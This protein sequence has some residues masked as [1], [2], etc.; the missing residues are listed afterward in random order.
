MPKKTTPTKY[1]SP[2]QKIWKKKDKRP[3]GILNLAKQ[4]FRWMEIQNYS[5][6]TIKGY[7][8]QL[9][10]FLS[11]CHESS[12]YQIH[13]I[14][15]KI[16][17]KYKIHLSQRTSKRKDSLISTSAQNDFLSVVC[18]FFRWLVK[19]E[20]VLNNSCEEVSY[21]PSTKK[22][23]RDTLNAEEVEHVL[24]QTDLT[25]AKGIRDRAIM[26][27][28]YSSGL[29]RGELFHLCIQD[30][31]LARGLILVIEGK[32]R[33]DRLVP[34]G[35]RAIKWLE[36]YLVEVRSRSM[37]KAS[38]N[39]L[40]LTMHGKAFASP[41]RFTSIVREYINT[42]KIEKKGSCHLLR[43]AMATGMLQGGASIRH[44]QKCLGHSDL[45]STEIYTKVTIPNLKQVHLETHPASQSE[46]E[47]I[48]QNQQKENLPAFPAPEKQS[49]KIHPFWQE[50]T[51]NNTLK[52]LAEK[53]LEHMKLKGRSLK[54]IK[55]T[56]FYLRTFL[57]WCTEREI[58]HPKLIDQRILSLF[59]SF[60]Y[61][62]K[63][64][65]GQALSVTVRKQQMIAIN[66]YFRYLVEQKHLS[67]NPALNIELPKSPIR[68]PRHVLTPEQVEEILNL[69]NTK[70]TLGIRD[71]AI[72]EVFYS[73]GIRRTE[74][75]NLILKDIDFYNQTILIRN[76]KGYKDRIIPIGE[77]ALQWL[78]EYLHQSRPLI[79]EREQP[80]LFLSGRGKP[81]RPESLSELIMLYLKKFGL[82]S[83]RGACHIFRH[84]MATHMLSAGAEIRYIQEI[85]GHSKVSVT[86][87]YTQVSIDQL[88]EVHN[89]THPAKLYPTKTFEI[90]RELEQLDPPRKS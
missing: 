46:P 36:K 19:Q 59:E 15:K 20:Y 74:L 25:T 13:Q 85:L 11:W 43:H 80:H 89:Q 78:T 70:T 90:I 21:Y 77:R 22:L 76:G 1:I 27:V 67:T 17:E 75:A 57:Q 16:I 2:S 44:V 29:R 30:L 83:Q 5:V 23:P 26:E 81:F 84:A 24:N 49:E 40:F 68:I 60:T 42:A 10:W 50:N 4:Y 38:E 45:S 34:L 3:N 28:L 61:Q 66:L 37:K 41:N 73:T 6:H 35:E 53:F 72:F 8:Y 33:K 9:G 7:R 51:P 47:V 69:P 65:K 62:R 58:H 52:P 82:Y 18:G 71:R 14:N 12:F 86:E 39:T 79:S 48:C 88:K 56:R 55:I 64:K 54:Y 87:I 63:N 32:G 31:D